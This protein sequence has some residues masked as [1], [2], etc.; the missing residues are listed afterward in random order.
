MNDNDNDDLVTHSLA[1]AYQDTAEGAE[2]RKAR[3]QSSF[4]ALGDDLE[5]RRR[6]DR[7]AADA[8][9]AVAPKLR[10][11]A[12]FRMRNQILR[13]AYG[14][15]GFTIANV[16][17]ADLPNLLTFELAGPGLAP[18][19]DLDEFLNDTGNLNAD[20][21]R[22]L[23]WERLNPVRIGF[24]QFS[25]HLT[26]G[27]PVSAPFV[28]WESPVFH[29]NIC[30]NPQPGIMPGTVC[31]DP[32]MDD[33]R[34]DLDFGYLCQLLV[35]IATYR[36]YDLA[37]AAT[38][39]DPLAALWARTESGQQLIQSIGGSPMGSV[40]WLSGPTGHRA[41]SAD[42]NNSAAAGIGVRSTCLA[43]LRREGLT[44][45]RG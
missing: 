36:A 23:P 5:E 27:F 6:I 39:P 29:P 1:S 38:F 7:I 21:F 31:L 22:A 14:N 17:N 28:V 12:Q 8:G 43:Q 32:L 33:W 35:D 9:I 20:D 10:M 3:F 41:A 34:P 45:T 15:P 18:P 40:T 2:R 37:E 24:H 13:Y 25:I 26:T 30:R 11:E 42:T 44:G 4:A 19:E 16:D